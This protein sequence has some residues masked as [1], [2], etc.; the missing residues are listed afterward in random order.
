M[1]D[2]D[3]DHDKRGRRDKFRGERNDYDNRRPMPRGYDRGGR[4]GDRGWQDRK[5]DYN[6]GN[7]DTIMETETIVIEEI[8]EGE[9]HPLRETNLTGKNI[10]DKQ[11]EKGNTN[12]VSNTD[13][14]KN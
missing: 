6:Y 3:D 1:G 11:I 10:F 12:S 5:R 13:Y 7:R 9:A 8:L 14:L 4:G 2:S